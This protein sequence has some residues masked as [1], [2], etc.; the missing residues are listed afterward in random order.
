MGAHSLHDDERVALLI[1]SPSSYSSSNENDE[2]T[3]KMSLADKLYAYDLTLATLTYQR[4]GQ[5]PRG[6][7]LWEA[8][9][10][11]GDGIMYVMRCASTLSTAAAAAC[12]SVSDI[13]LCCDVCAYSIW[14]GGC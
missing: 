3:H 11:T 12:W 8:L 2:Q 14:A 13:T 1:R 5:N 9:S 7:L 10:H 4:W 6:R